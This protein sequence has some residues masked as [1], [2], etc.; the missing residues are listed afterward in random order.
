M[1]RMVK[2]ILGIVIFFRFD[3]LVHAQFRFN[4]DV[5]DI[6]SEYSLQVWTKNDGLPSNTLHNIVKGDD[7]FLWIGT[8][9]GLV[10]FDG[11]EF[12]AFTAGNTPQIK[13]NITA[14]LFK[15]ASGKIWFSNGGAGLVIMDQEKFERL[16]EDDGLSINHPSSFAEGTD[17]KMYIGTFGG[18]LNIFENNHFSVIN[19]KDGLSSN[20]M[21]SILLDRNERLWIGTYDEGI[22]LLDKTGIKKFIISP[23]SAVE[24]IFQES[25]GTILAGTHNGVYVFNGKSFEAEKEFFPLRGK[26]I[27]H[28]SEDSEGN[29]WF[30]T[31][32]NGIYV[33]NHQNFYNLTTQNLLPTDKIL[34]VLPTENGIWI[35]SADGGLFILKQNKIKILSELQRIPDKIIRTIFQAPDDALWIGTKDGIAKYDERKKIVLPFKTTLKDFSVHAWAANAKGEIFLGTLLQGIFK[36][37]DNTLVQVAD[38]KL[39]KVSYI[40]SL[41]FDNDG[42]LWIGTNG[43]GVI[44]LKDGKV[45]FI[46]KA[47]GLSSDFIACICKDRK[48]NFW[49]GTSGGGISVLDST[50]KILKT[51]TDKEGLANNIVNSII[52]DEEGVIWVGTS[53]SGISRIKDNSIFNFNERNGLYS[54]T[55]KK[56][57]YDGHTTFWATSNQ[58]V[59][60][61]EKKAFNNV[62]NG[63]TEKLVFSLF[64]KNDGMIDDDFL[65][66][67]DNAGCISRTGKIYAPSHDGVVIIDPK[68]F[69]T[70]AEPPRVYIDDVF[71]NYKERT[72]DVLKDL[73]PNTESVQ[74][75]YGGISFT[76]GKYLKYK[77]ILGGIDK[78]WV[79][80]GTRRQ[81]F[82]THLPH[83]SYTFKIVAVTPE[84]TE[85]KNAALINFTIH[86]YFWQTFWFQALSAVVILGL[87]TI[88]LLF[89]FKRKY[90]RKV[91]IIEAEAALER[92][93]MRISKDM[94]DE[95]GASLTKISLMSDLAKRNLEDPGQLKKDLNSIS[96]ASRNVASS[97]DE[98]V[99]AVNPKNDSL[100]KTI[101]YFIH[102]IEDYLS[103]TEIEFAV[104]IPDTIPSRYLNAELRHNLFLVLKE[105]VNNIVKH[106]G[107]DM[108]K[109]SISLENSS[110]IL[111]LEDNGIGI[112][113]SS[114]DQFSNGLKNMSKRIEDFEGSMEI[115][116]SS[117]R[118][119]KITLKL[120]L[121]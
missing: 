63:K 81:V 20:D 46:D 25:N 10:R 111:S 98:I 33:Y 14:D 88:Y 89:Y 15:D 73:S 55:L 41:K 86:P 100:E 106:S 52:E 84:G 51:I 26:T 50:G 70:K 22:N 9:N 109:L 66:V 2:L 53:V 113:L 37:V 57:L 61:I 94:H 78:D 67:A 32:N 39:L 101:F 64:G 76:H 35:C 119:A 77:Y 40:R 44:L 23:N 96:E 114:V 83:G 117:P 110:F 19:K 90:K 28:I 38:R 118:G 92:E 91:K 18:G 45:K 105:A 6:R 58:G 4:F 11:S 49:I 115:L 93:R 104:A 103:S 120:P 112:D 1:Y 47:A 95:L 36:I 80:V 56:L 79:F 31:S 60:S 7:G 34:Q 17:G 97:M 121:Q 116:N 68:L 69:K 75:N 16:S 87:T 102:Y 71:V 29:I 27:N 5:K 62:A 48:N 43:A 107:A 13:A 24:H 3:F 54:N 72:K 82:F 74:I 42:T 21:H 65:A 85:S 8:S 30:S 108:V 99:W 59:F 12:K